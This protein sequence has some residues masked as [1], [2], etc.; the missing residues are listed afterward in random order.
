MPLHLG[1]RE[2]QIWNIWRKVFNPVLVSL[3][4]FP[5]LFKIISGHCAL[6]ELAGMWCRLCMKRPIND[7]FN[8]L[9]KIKFYLFEIDVRVQQELIPKFAH[10]MG[11]RCYD[12]KWSLTVKTLIWRCIILKL[13]WKLWQFSTIFFLIFALL[14]VS[15]LDISVISKVFR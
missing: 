15:Y 6:S 1:F 14:Q 4:V 8:R 13:S 9:P 2:K 5:I 3:K 12:T 7:I 11:D 10:Q